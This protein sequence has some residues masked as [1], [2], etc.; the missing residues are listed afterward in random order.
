MSDSLTG[1]LSWLGYTLPV[2]VPVSSWFDWLEN[3]TGLEVERHP[4]RAAPVLSVID[5]RH[6]LVDGVDLREFARLDDL[7]AWLFL[8]VS[9]VMVSRG[10]FTT[11]HA[12][13]VTVAGRAL[14][15]PGPPWSGKSSWALEARRRGLD[16]LGDDQVHVDPRSG[17]AFGL[18]RPLKCRLP[19]GDAE[20]G[21]SQ[22]AVRAELEG[23]SIALEPRRA[24][25]LAPVD[26][27]Y[28][29][30]RIIHLVRHRGPGVEV[31]VLDRFRS[32]QSI[33]GQIRAYSP[34]FLADAA[35]LAR[36]LG[37]LPNVRM[38]V[39]DGEI[40]RALDLALDLN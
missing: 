38:S 26:R 15:I 1:T 33:L 11:L 6:V 14:L 19:A 40:G 7:K 21:L 36:V 9:D 35:A 30:A 27:G 23:E 22:D 28:A 20:S 2:A 18:P 24:E 29:P 25:G 3:F 16:V 4:R 31:Q 17:L 10:G 34:R 37:R 32:F 12:A 8:T 39:G 13:G 5:D